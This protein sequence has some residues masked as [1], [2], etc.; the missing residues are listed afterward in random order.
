[1]RINYSIVFVSDMDRSVAFYRDVL[2]L[3]VIRRVHEAQPG[4]LGTRIPGRGGHARAIVA[5][6]GLQDDVDVLSLELP[7]RVLHEVTAVLQD[8]ALQVLG[9]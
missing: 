8:V 2:G 7:V 5:R 6:E 3:E 4:A 9:A 1:M